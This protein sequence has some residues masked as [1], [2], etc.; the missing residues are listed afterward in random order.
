MTR[1]LAA[2]LLTVI[3]VAGA[4]AEPSIEV[5]PSV[6][7]LTIGDRLELFVTV[8]VEQ[9]SERLD[10]RFQPW[11]E[12]LGPAEILAVAPI[13]QLQGPDGSTVYTQRLVLTLFRL[14]EVT[15]PPVEATVIGAHGETP[16]TSI[17]TRLTVRSVLP[18]GSEDIEAKPPAPPR[19]PGMGRS[20]WWSA[21]A[22]MATCL[23]A[24]LALWWQAEGLDG[25]SKGPPR[26]APMEELRRSLLALR[27]ETEVVPLH[28]ELS[29]A[30]RRYLGRALTFQALE[31][32]TTEVRRELR[33]RQLPADVV[34]QTG[35][36][37]AACDMVKFARRS[38]DMTAA[39]SRI[40]TAKT[41]ADGIAVAT[42][43]IEPQGRAGTDLD[44][45]DP[46]RSNGNRA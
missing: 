21:T 7:E 18:E 22:L 40:G 30:V 45:A 9:T 2:I 15:L 4:E 31:R 20:F 29:L 37:L 39:R 14:G 1:A 10:V 34:R 25:D 44:A 19:R 42:A 16:L 23:V 12:T 26:L 5:A 38:V 17:S 11:G 33:G 24:L 27:S 35:D 13:E 41:I 3:S 32:T 6:A 43:P 46:T 8:R 28:A 36:L